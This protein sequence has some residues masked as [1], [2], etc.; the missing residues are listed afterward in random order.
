MN[1]KDEDHQK[2]LKDKFEDFK[3]S[4]FVKQELMISLE[5][6][7]SEREFRDLLINTI[8]SKPYHK[9]GTI[10]AVSASLDTIRSM[11]IELGAQ[12]NMFLC[13][14][15]NYI[16]SEVEPIFGEVVRYYGPEGIECV[17]VNNIINE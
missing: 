15:T 10:V 13:V 4:R 9:V 6:P 11:Q 14:D 8:I 12:A 17:F 16:K 5:S 3:Y 1:K 7:I 2:W